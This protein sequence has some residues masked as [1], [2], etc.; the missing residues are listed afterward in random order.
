MCLKEIV[1]LLLTTCL[2][3]GCN[4]PLSPKT[5]APRP[6]ACRA[7]TAPSMR[8]WHL[9][10][11]PN[12]S[13]SFVALSTHTDCDLPPLFLPPTWGRAPSPFPAQ[14]PQDVSRSWHLPH[15]PDQGELFPHF[16]LYHPSHL[17]DKEPAVGTPC[18]RKVR[19]GSH[20]LPSFPTTRATSH[21]AQGGEASMFLNV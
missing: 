7:P 15:P 18:E 21:C 13:D 1:T 3:P 12:F 9:S 10:Q 14:D 19:W 8:L 17:G 11:S 16:S 6:V 4:S 20:L 5:L 2:K